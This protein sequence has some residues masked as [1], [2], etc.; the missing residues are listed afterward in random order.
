MGN[1]RRQLFAGLVLLV[2]LLFGPGVT[3]ATPACRFQLG[4]ATLAAL[5]PT[6][7]GACLDGE[8]HNPANGDALRHTT[9]GLLVWRK[10]DNFTAFTSGYRS[11]INGPYGLQE[12]LNTQRFSWESDAGTAGLQV[13]YIRSIAIDAPVAGAMVSSPVEVRGRVAVTPFEATLGYRIYDHNGRLVGRGPLMVNGE[14]GKPG[15]F[16]AALPFADGAGGLG[17]IE[18]LDLS[19]KDGSVLAGVSV[20]VRLG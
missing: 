13:L 10:A 11:S 3:R 9:K 2:A 5:I 18:I 20:G 8:A 19:P 14:M 16:R 12:R 15:T 7:V 6:E 4:F 17:T 1:V